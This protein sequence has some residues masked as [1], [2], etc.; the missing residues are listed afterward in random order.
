VKRLTFAAPGDLDTPT[1]GYAYDRRVIEELRA[2]GWEIDVLDVGARFP[3]PTQADRE[4]ASRLLAAARPDAPLV[5]DGL[6][7]GVIP[8]IARALAETHRLVALV[9]HPLAYETGVTEEE[10]EALRKSEAVA[11]SHM[12]HVITSSPATARILAAEYGVPAE[13]ISV[14]I[15]GT[16]PARGAV[17]ASGAAPLHLLA[18]GSLVPRKGYDVLI[19]ALAKLSDLP[20]RLTVIGDTTR[21]AATAQS[22]QTMARDNNLETRIAFIGTV[23]E[24]ALEAAYRHADVFV[25]PSHFEGF[26][27]AA[28]SAIAYGLPVIATRGGALEETVGAAALL[29]APGDADALAAALRRVIGDAAERARLARAARDAATRQQRW[30][31]T[32]QQFA[33]AIAAT[34]GETRP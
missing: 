3:R 11:L 6:A 18:V 14:A 34:A 5:I 15:P 23:S 17:R 32:A 31:T 12:R 1:G 2:L 24:A 7:L 21:D 16:D 4:A 27:M 33:A 10:E 9:H 29:V 19:R 13:R 8:E 26:G 30:Q 22:L 25:Q 28:A 20:W